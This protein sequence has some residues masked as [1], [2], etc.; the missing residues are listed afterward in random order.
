[1]RERTVVQYLKA[2]WHLQEQRPKRVTVTTL[3]HSLT[4]APA[5]V[6]Q[7]I[8][9]LSNAG[10]VQHQPYGP[11]ALTPHGRRAAVTAIRKERVARAF[12]FKV[13]DVPWPYVA[14][15]SA[16]LSAALTCRLAERMYQAAGLPSF[17][18]YGNPIPDRSGHL[19]WPTGTALGSHDA[20]VDLHITRVIEHDR[21]LLERFHVLGLT[22][23]SMVQ[24]KR[25]DHTI[26]VIEIS[27][28]AGEASI[29]IAIADRIY[30]I[31]R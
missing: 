25:I 2:I 6:S 13:L 16:R 28:S 1:M 27:T 26:G 8:K 17:D 10:L 4:K 9:K 31:T 15:E 22:P 20:T 18:P 12:L 19:R 3:T 5:T 24:I 23:D 11:I 14:E 21:D 29:G 30:A 7:A